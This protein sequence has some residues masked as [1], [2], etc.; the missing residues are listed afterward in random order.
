MCRRHNLVAGIV[1]NHNGV[2]ALSGGGGYNFNL[3]GHA[4]FGRRAEEFQ[5]IGVAKFFGGFQ[6]AFVGLIKNQDAQEFGQQHHF[7]AFATS[8][9]FYGFG[10]FG[11]LFF[12]NFSCRFFRGFWLFGFFFSRRRR[13]RFRRTAAA[14]GQR[15]H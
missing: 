8:S 1:G 5:A 15:Q 6:R 4:V 3:A 14:T 11:R 2:H 9:F 10:L 12:F 13:V 7:H